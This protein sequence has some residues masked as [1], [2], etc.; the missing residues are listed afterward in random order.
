MIDWA[1]VTD[2]ETGEELPFDRKLLKEIL[3]DPAYEELL[4]FLITSS[5][6][7]VLFRL[8]DADAKN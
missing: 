6:D 2:D 5:G 3:T 8:G 1:N 4:S 7:A